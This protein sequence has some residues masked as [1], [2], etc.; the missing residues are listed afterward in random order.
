MIVAL[1]I[2]FVAS[3]YLFNKN[4]IEQNQENLKREQALNEVA[5]KPKIT[6]DVKHQFKDGKH[7]FVGKVQTP[8]PCHKLKKTVT[9]NNSDFYLNIDISE[10]EAGTVCAQVITDQPFYF[11][12]V[13]QESDVIYARL[14][15]ELVNLNIFEIPADKEIED[16]E[17]Y[18]KG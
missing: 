1:I 14:N 5:N 6:L 3:G 13:G 15:G 11:D 10:P 9:K 8:S 12:F 4:K 18:L 16:I 17:I 7:I 2:I